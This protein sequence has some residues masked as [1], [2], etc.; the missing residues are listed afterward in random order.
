MF[1]N[2]QFS[3]QKNVR[4]IPSPKPDY[5][6]TPRVRGFGRAKNKFFNFC[7]IIFVYCIWYFPNSNIILTLPLK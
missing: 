1:S 2:H 4:P 3:D 7:F 6:T 5:W